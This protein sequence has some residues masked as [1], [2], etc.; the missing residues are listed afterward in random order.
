MLCIVFRR[1]VLHC[2]VLRCTVYL[3]FD[4]PS[5]HPHHSPPLHSSTSYFPSVQIIAVYYTGDFRVQHGRVSLAFENKSRT[6]QELR[7]LVVDVPTVEFLNIKV[8]SP[9]S[10]IAGTD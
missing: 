5:T 6:E 3:H 4:L 1:A 10:T 9:N 7:H 2:A 8:Q